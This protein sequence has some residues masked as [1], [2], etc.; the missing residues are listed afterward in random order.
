[1]KKITFIIALCLLFGCAKENLPSSLETDSQT[2]TKEEALESFAKILSKA[3]AANEPI[4]EFIKLKAIEQFDCDYDVF[5]P[6]VKD[7]VLSSGVTF[8]NALL[9]VCEDPEELSKIESACPKLNILVP[10]WS[11]IGVFCAKTWDTSDDNVLVGFDQKGD[12]HTL[13]KNGR[14]HLELSISEIP[15]SPTLIVKENERIKVIE[16]KSGELIF[17]FK[18]KEFDRSLEPVTRGRAWYEDDIDLSYN[19]ISDFVPTSDIDPLVIN[20]YY[21]FGQNYSGAGCQR[22]YIYY[23][24]SK[25]NQNN[26]ILNENIREQFYRFKIN[27]SAYEKM[28]DQ[29]P[30]PSLSDPIT[31]Y[32]KSHQLSAEDLMKRIWSDGHFEFTFNFYLG[33]YGVNPTSTIY[34]YTHSCSAEEVFDL[35]KVHRK[36]KHQTAV[37][38]GEYIYYFLPK[39][40]EPKWIHPTGSV[41]LPKWDISEKSNIFIVELYEE[42]NSQTYTDQHEVTFTYSSNF[43]VDIE[44]E[45]TSDNNKRKISLGI[46]DTNNKQRSEHNVTTTQTTLNSDRLG[47]NELPYVIK[48]VNRPENQLINGVLKSGY[49]INPVDFGAFSITFLPRDISR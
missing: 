42:D 1:M 6:F 7:E 10:D 32:G 24:M 37:A 28:S 18:H 36:Y 48:I 26:G 9:E 35:S 20:A 33:Q 5:Y 31:K 44:A 4:R 2:M 41:Y 17:D 3:V 19:A 16:T 29:N 23:G 25:T 8:R 38:Q 22:D 47:A 34:S 46:K 27:T 30:D 49:S 40:L 11:W 15:E 39:N 21:E 45:G 14:N 13:Y 43:S 12:T